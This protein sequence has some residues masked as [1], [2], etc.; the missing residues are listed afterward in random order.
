MKHSAALAIASLFLTANI[1]VAQFTP[2][3]TINGTVNNAQT[4]AGGTGSVTVTGNLSVSGNNVVAATVTGTSTIDNLRDDSTKPE[5][6]RAAL[7][8]ARSG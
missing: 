5:R 7:R 2:D 3:G 1:A 4:L 8:D 6:L